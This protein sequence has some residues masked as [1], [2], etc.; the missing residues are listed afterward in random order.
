MDRRE[1]LISAAV[2]GTAAMVAT[3][4]SASAQGTGATPSTAGQ[5]PFITTRDGTRLFYIDWGRGKPILFVHGW[6]LCTD[7]WEHQT[8]ARASDAVRCVAYDRRGHG[9]SSQPGHGYDF[10]TLAD[11]L[12]AV[13]EQR[14]LRD[15][16]L[17]GHSMGSLEVAQYL[18]RHG[19]ARIARVVL[20]S[21]N[22]PY[23]LKA[24]DNPDGIDKAVFDAFAAA[25]LKDRPKFLA[26]G[27]SGLLGAGASAS[28]EMVQWAL[29]LFLRTSLKAAVD[30]VRLFTTADFRSH[31]R[32]FAMPTLVIQGDQDNVNP[33]ELSGRKTVQA[34]PG[35]QLKVYAGAPHGP[36]ITDRDRFNSDLLAFVRG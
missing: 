18:S 29:D 11:D 28:P 12:A 4:R 14:D 17:V 7:I 19:A 27:M 26:T 35:S 10:D 34:I 20:V 21:P 2:A 22:T 1:M 5:E 6:S 31:M 32:L 3:A 33:L 15:V 24:A 9:R 36:F 13:I 25:L 16:T 30:L 8:T 23:L